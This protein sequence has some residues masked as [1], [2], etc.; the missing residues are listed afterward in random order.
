ME[1]AVLKYCTDLEV[2]SE[3]GTPVSASMNIPFTCTRWDEIS[4][5]VPD[6]LC[7]NEPN[8]KTLQSMPSKPV[9]F[10]SSMTYKSKLAYPGNRVGKSYYVE[11]NKNDCDSNEQNG[12]NHSFHGFRKSRRIRRYRVPEHVQHR[13]IRQ[14][15]AHSLLC[16][17]HYVLTPDSL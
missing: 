11:D 16:A 3:N 14:N 12:C 17:H 5:M 4:T 7:G 10:K 2:S 13:D 6:S 15:G 8:I 1:L 9:V